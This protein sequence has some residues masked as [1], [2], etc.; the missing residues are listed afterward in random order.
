[1]ASWWW[2]SLP[3]RSPTCSDQG[4]VFSLR[5]FPTL[6]NCGRAECTTPYCGWGSLPLPLWAW[7][8]CG[9][10]KHRLF[11]QQ[12]TDSLSTSRTASL[13]LKN[14]TEKDWN[15][16]C[17]FSLADAAAGAI[18]PVRVAI[19]NCAK[20]RLTCCR[21]QGFVLHGFLCSLFSCACWCA[22][23]VVV[24]VIAWPVVSASVSPILWM[25]CL[26]VFGIWA[27]LDCVTKITAPLPCKVSL[28]EL[29]I[30]SVVL[31]HN[32]HQIVYRALTALFSP[33]ALKLFKGSRPWS[34]HC[35]CTLL[36]AHCAHGTPSLYLYNT[37]WGIPHFRKPPYIYICMYI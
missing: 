37:F 33:L 18:A 31:F 6:A 2:L 24:G 19:A 4:I 34:I 22:C 8:S 16:D 32:W 15:T 5:S 29:S 12:I 35:T 13:S 9:L 26:C 1:M 3:L 14:A 27:H 17:S 25:Y 21:G 36:Y 20:A 10:Y 30:S 11:T 23:V 7:D 28:F